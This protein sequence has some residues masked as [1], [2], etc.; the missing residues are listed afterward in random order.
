MNHWLHFRSRGLFFRTAALAGLLAATAGQTV[1]LYGDGGPGYTA[2][3]F[4]NIGA[5]TRSAG[6]GEAFTAVANDG[7][8]VAWNVAGLSQLMAKEILFMHSEWVQ[9]VQYEYLSYGQNLSNHQGLGFSLAYLH[10]DNMPVINESAVTNP[11][12]I[13]GSSPVITNE[14]VSVK[15]L[16]ATIAYSRPFSNRLLVGGAVKFIQQ[17]LVDQSST[18]FAADLGGMYLNRDAGWSL[19][20]TLSNLGPA[21]AGD[22]MPMTIRF[23]GAQRMRFSDMMSVYSDKELEPSKRRDILFTVDL[24][25]T[26][27]ESTIKTYLGSEWRFVFDVQYVSVRMG[28]RF[29]MTKDGQGV[30]SFGLGYV[31]SQDFAEWEVD[32]CYAP[33]TDLGDTNRFSFGIRF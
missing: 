30:V 16:A 23:G 17:T 3:N 24:A 6:M 25:D 12:D 4:L 21:M 29:E 1:P 9:G 20:A 19:G 10:M 14:T 26:L 8:A 33:F 7:E 28:Y 27:S 32:Y 31:L 13:L 11:G 22:P 2:A 15:D 18:D 5:G